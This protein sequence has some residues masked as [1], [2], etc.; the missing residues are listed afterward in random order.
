VSE[1]LIEA[2]TIRGN[3]AQ[4]GAGISLQ[5]CEAG[6]VI[7]NLIVDNRAAFATPGSSGKG[8]G[9]DCLVNLNA[10]NLVIA[11]NTLVGNTAPAIF[12]SE[13]GGAV[14]MTLIRNNLTIA[15]N[16]IVSNSSGIWRLPGST[17]LPTLRNNCVNNSNGVNYLNLSAGPND[18]SADPR[19]AN[20]TG[21]DFHLQASSPCIDTG[22]V[23]DAPSFDLDGV[24]RPLDG[25]T[26]GVARSDIGAFEFAHPSADSDADGMRDTLE[27]IAGTNPADINSVLRVRVRFN[28]T[29]TVVL[30]TWPSATGRTY[31]VESKPDL[32]PAGS[33]ETLSD[34]MP[35]TGADVEIVD[36]RAVHSNR[37]YRVQVEKN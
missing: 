20:R 15:N 10:T 37:L 18:F 14:A 22:S 34:H 21:G 36:A 23:M 13:L 19:L 26:N 17:L 31:R 6:R 32:S 3:V 30:L 9:I 1:F 2:N 24:G 27:I 16:I 7:K 11:N 29:R 33:W 25:D 5:S 8:G 28:T 35:G 4:A 12:G